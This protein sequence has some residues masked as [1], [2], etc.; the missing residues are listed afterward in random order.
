MDLTTKYMGMTLKN[1]IVASSSPLSHKVDSIKRLEDAGAAAVVM[2]SLF[3]EQINSE[4]YYLDYYLGQGIDSFGESLSY[5]PEMS[6][7]NIGPE[8]YI[9]LIR[10]AKQAVGIPII[11]SLNGISSGGWIDYAC[12]IEEAGADALEL[13]VYYIPT[14]IDM[15]GSEVENI[16]VEILRDVKRVV[17]VP[18][19]MKLSPFFSST[20]NMASRLS[21][22]GA[23]AL[24][25]FNRFYQP[26]FDLENLEV[27]PHLVLSGSDELRL[28]LRWVAILYGQIKAELAITSGIHT[29][30][31]VLKALMAGARAAMMASEL[32]QNGVQRIDEILLEMVRWMEDHEYVSVEQMIGSM[33]QQHVLEPA[34][35]ER[36]N[37]MKT[38]ASFRPIR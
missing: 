12:L 11:G 31:D 4:S 26:D 37:Y 5:F 22:A 32:L 24:V 27:V 16:Y 28:P 35:F 1:P 18:V 38:L 23:D 30:T 20:A 25:L 21:N 29:S 19:A 17:R 8:D 13:N 33:S 3:E 15:K 2:Y 36:A 10:K 9:D 34:A 6:G 7:Y 14:S